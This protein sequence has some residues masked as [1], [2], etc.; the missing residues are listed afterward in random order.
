MN[1]AKSDRPAPHRRA[2]AA[3]IPARTPWPKA[4]A[5]LTLGAAI[6]LVGTGCQT[7][8]QT[9]AYPAAYPAAAPYPAHPS[10]YPVATTVAP[11]ATG[12]I[13]QPAPYGTFAASPTTA[14][15]GSLAPPSLPGPTTAAPASNNWTWAQSS[16]PTAPPT[17]QQYGNQ[18][19]N[20]AQQYAN[21]L[22]QQP[23]QWANQAQQY[24]NQQSQQLSNQL[25]NTAN[26]YGQQ[27]NNQVNQFG[28]QTQAALQQQQQ[29]LS[30]QMQQATNQ[31][32]QSLP[33][34]PQQ[35]T[36]NGNW[37]PF[38]SPAGMPPAR[39]TPAQPVKY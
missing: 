30:G 18:M 7:P 25:Q 39:S 2:P 32:Q 26:Q 15:A 3:S 21:Q 37:W 13:G 24:A 19:Q 1:R 33:Q 38:T 5:I 28:A 6:V 34:V 29:A 9:A 36:A 23:Q 16:Q 27:F 22:Q 4:G 17:I 20:Q 10:A 14:P 12:A 35:Q 8:Q 11:P 31:L